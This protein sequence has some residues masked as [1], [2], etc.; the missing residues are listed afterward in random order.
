V[1]APISVL[2]EPGYSRL[3]TGDSRISEKEFNGIGGYETHIT[4]VPICGTPCLNFG[5]SLPPS[6]G[7]FF[8]RP[9]GSRKAI[10]KKT[11]QAS[12]AGGTWG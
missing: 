8:W 7:R 5:L 12:L 3:E 6:W 1:P 9:L 10:N 4:I 2:A 11:D